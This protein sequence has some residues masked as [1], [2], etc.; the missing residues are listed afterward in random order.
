MRKAWWYE[1]VTI[2]GGVAGYLLEIGV[3]LKGADPTDRDGH[4]WL[5]SP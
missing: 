1:V 5:V 3:L 4:E 2:F